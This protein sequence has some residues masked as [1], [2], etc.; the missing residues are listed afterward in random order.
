MA[1]PVTCHRASHKEL[2]FFSYLNMLYLMDF[3]AGSLFFF[4]VA[5]TCRGKGIRLGH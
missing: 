3:Y 2:H 1:R 5:V 4:P